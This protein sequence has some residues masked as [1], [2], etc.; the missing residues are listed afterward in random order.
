MEPSEKLTMS[1]WLVFHRNDKT[2]EL[3]F[4]IRW[5]QLSNQAP[6]RYCSFVQLTEC[7]PIWWLQILT[8][9]NGVF[10]DWLKCTKFGMDFYRKKLH[11]TSFYN[12]RFR[13]RNLPSAS[14]CVTIDGCDTNDTNWFGLCLFDGLL[15]I[16]WLSFALSNGCQA[17]CA[18]EETWK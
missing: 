6:M 14:R 1:E 2:Y 9:K 15:S 18:I 4:A 13:S 3:L 7:L 8:I 17:R 11:E 12:F 16:S 10:C 5:W